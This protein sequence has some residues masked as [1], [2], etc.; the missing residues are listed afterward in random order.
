MTRVLRDNALCACMAL[1]GTVTMVWMGLIGFAWTD[2]EVEV[3]PSYQALVHGHLS[4]FLRLVPAYGGSLIE[5]APFALLPG[6][7]SGGDLAVY[8]SVALPCLLAAAA[9]GVYL[10][11]YMRGSGHSTLA[12]AVALGI[13]V[14]NPI[15]LRGLEF[16]HPED[17]LGGCMCVAAVLLAARDRPLLAGLVLGLAI[18]NK[19]WALLAAG[20]VRASPPWRCWPRSRSPPPARSPRARASSPRRRAP[21]FSR[22]RCGGSSACT[23]AP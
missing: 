8:R 15:T 10:V 20:P 1:L 13:C 12:R 2:Y 4:A 7:W 22:G 5:R 16:G 6:L 21:T 11:A 23:G 9:L 3:L 14:A 19:E 18:A 17:L